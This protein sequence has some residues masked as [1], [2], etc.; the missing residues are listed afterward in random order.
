[1]SIEAWQVA[2]EIARGA[3]GAADEE[4]QAA[5]IELSLQMTAN[6][7][8]PLIQ[9]DHEQWVAAKEALDKANTEWTVIA[10][11]APVRPSPTPPVSGPRFAS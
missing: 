5:D 6:A 1:M 4:F 2:F 7:A 8:Q 3:V 9:A 11:I 10:R